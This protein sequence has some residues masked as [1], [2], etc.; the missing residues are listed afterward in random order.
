MTRPPIA[1]PVPFR[2]KRLVGFSVTALLAAAAVLAIFLRRGPGPTDRPRREAAFALVS[3][4]RSIEARLSYAPADSYR[5]YDVVRGSTAALTA[6]GGESIPLQVLAELEE[7][8]DQH[9]V[10]AGY[11]LAGDA[12][13]AALH[14]ERAAPTI[15][16]QS[17]RAVILLGKGKSEEALIA[18]DGVL[19]IAPRHPQARWNR[20]LA[21]R[22]LGLTFMAEQAFSQI[23]AANEPGWSEEASAR[24]HS[25]GE[26]ARARRDAFLSLYQID[27]LARPDGLAP[28]LIRQ[29]PSTVRLFLYEAVRSA[30]SAAAV[31]SLL[32]LARELDQVYGGEVL[33]RYL[34]HVAHADF[35]RRGPLAA[36]YHALLAR[37][38]PGPPEEFLASVRKAGQDDIL[39][40]G[41]AA[42]GQVD[43]KVAAAHLAELRALAMRSQDPWLVSLAAAQEATVLVAAG[44]RN[45]AEALVRPLLDRCD[46]GMESPCARLGLVLGSIAIEEGRLA[47]AR[48]VLQSGWQR[49]QRS[50]GWYAEQQ[51]LPLLAVLAGRI[52]DATEVGLP[53]VA[54]YAGELEL[55]A[56]E[57]CALRI[58]S[59]QMLAIML[60][61]RGDGDAA[62]EKVRTVQEARKTCG[63]A[64]L[65]DFSALALSQVVRAHGTAE[66]I[67][68][69][70]GQ[71]DALRAQTGLSAA[72]LAAVDD[73][74]ARLVIDHD[75]HDRS[76]GRKLFEGAIARAELP[77]SQGPRAQEARAF[78]YAGLALD[79]GRANEWDGALSSMAADARVTLPAAC[80]V[81]VLVDEERLLVVV[82]DALGVSRG[83]YGHRPPARTIDATRIVPTELRSGLEACPE[84]S[85]LASAP[86]HGQPGLLSPD[87]PWAYVSER[88]DP[89]RSAIDPGR[90]RVVIA[91]VEPP[92]P[93]ELPRLAAWRT[94]DAPQV[95]LDGPAATPER[96]LAEM[97]DADFI[98]IHAHG[99]VDMSVSDAAFLIL[100][101]GA[102]GDYT[103]TAAAIARTPLRSRP[104]VI[105]AACGSAMTASYYRERWNLP[106]AFLRAG[107]RSVI[108]SPSI[109]QDSEAGAFFD[110]VRARIDAG[111]SV[112]T[113]LR[114]ARKSWLSTHPSAGWVRS[115]LVFQSR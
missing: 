20:A 92:R 102:D 78:A 45:R 77:E 31:R 93:F 81:G 62:M 68:V 11:L 14:L 84:I 108:A 101:P 54:A 79:A 109:I 113:S 38:L 43:G 100:S 30:P 89:A 19:E 37:Q 9:G 60:L 46:M 32:P 1:A 70:R 86:V 66:E 25:L 5:P 76:L 56:P 97:R 18:L 112:A 57:R 61:D 73:A 64:P 63:A 51:Y 91:D 44:E 115:L 33:D 85:V 27:L 26:R 95:L 88:A 83:A 13:A 106:A 17:D 107:A 15:D 42:V 16:V 47:A 98:E 59:A 24:A 80:A 10:A 34:E 96:V 71:I 111:Q 49:A 67:A 52:D 6:A 39:L 58:W 55:R 104:I 48:A 105:L 75:G 53:L 114:D 35:A 22:D 99:M 8:G 4:T 3:P 87:L 103:L 40:G 90:R 23:A 50:G 12:R 29:F 82:R 28:E 110:G 65:D 21:L 69:L 36:K 7:R 94:A 2:R 74:E 72:A 41:L